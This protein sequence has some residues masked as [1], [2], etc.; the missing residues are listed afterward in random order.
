MT[1]PAQSRAMVFVAPDQPLELRT[2]AVPA[3]VAGEAIVRIECA[4][5]C[6]SDFHTIAGH[7][8]EP[9]P[10]ILGH[11]AIGTVVAA[12]DPPPVDTAGESIVPGDRVAWS[13]II[14]CHQC[15]RC[16][17][18]LPQKCRKLQKYGHLA[19]DDGPALS[20]G[21]AEFIVIRPGSTLIKLAGHWPRD[22]FCPV[23]CAT[24]TVAAALRHIGSPQGGSVLITGAGMLG[25]TSVAWCHALG[26]S[27]IVVADTDSQRAR[28]AQ[29]FGAD[30]VTSS[31][32][33]EVAEQG[34]DFAMEMSGAS[35]AVSAILE[36]IAVGGRIALAGAARPVDDV[37]LNPE[38]VLRRCLAI[39]GI[40]NY[41]PDDLVAAADF[42]SRFGDRYP[43]AALVTGPFPLAQTNEAVREASTSRRHRVMIVPDLAEDSKFTNRPLTNA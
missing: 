33:S 27:R 36:T 28:M 3:P 8:H 23:G 34:F 4:T 13:P 16:R 37:P 14:A 10:S 30:E 21:L 41:V 38:S 42:L 20:G 19:I 43:F 7:R 1:T 17:R 32:V 6:G 12:G 22:V 25:L 5:I 11:E 40:H 39:Y 18:S 9:R 26:A 31:A 24:A 2:F 15:D 35:S 29:D